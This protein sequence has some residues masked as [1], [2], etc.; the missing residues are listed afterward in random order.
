MDQDTPSSGTNRRSSIRKKPR[1]KLRLECRRGT[2]GLGQ[3]LAQSL[4][5]LSQTG[6]CL[7]VGPG[8]KVKDE[9]EIIVSSTAAPRPVKV[10]GTVV[11]CEALDASRFSIGVRFH[12]QISYQD[13]N[14]LT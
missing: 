13:L 11:W 3:N 12:K 4:L 8:L 1:G 5:D 6:A 7:I 10:H 9:V 14:N 2:I